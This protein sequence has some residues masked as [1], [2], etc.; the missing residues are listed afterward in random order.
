MKT[1][2]VRPMTRSDLDMAVE[3]AAAEGW[4]PGLHDADTFWAAD[5]GG[6]LLGLLE[7]EPVATISA[8]RYGGHFGFIGFYIVR[9]EFRGQGHGIALWRDAME[10]LA[11]RTIG[12]DGVVAQQDSYR[13]SG[14]E[15]AW[16]NVRHE[17][18]AR[19]C[20]RPDTRVVP[21]DPVGQ[22]TPEL[23]EYDA[24]FFPD[25]R[26]RFVQHWITQSGSTALA[27]RRGGVLAGYGVIRP[28][29]I[30][31]KIGPLFADDADV[32]DRL[33]RALISRLRPGEP[34]QLDTPAT[35]PLAL[36]LAR[37][38]GMR[39]VFE[40]A[41]MYAGVAPDLPIRRLFGITTFEL[42]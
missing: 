36:E 29:R 17:G 24:A 4:N 10:R 18:V 25:D 21:V 40:T 16:N 42:G 32:A 9:P 39:P 31:F 2:H 22:A 7:S 37:S 20:E 15:L 35:N 38:H 33:L 11:G 13:K 28:C 19:S 26:R 41:R 3:W 23:L 34:I 8:V 5:P 14:F 27:A 6:F 1:F 30:G 12:L